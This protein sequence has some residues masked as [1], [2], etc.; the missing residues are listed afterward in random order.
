MQPDAGWPTQMTAAVS[1][2]DD[3]DIF[4]PWQIRR[5]RCTYMYLGFREELGFGK[6][7]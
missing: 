5:M 7:L 4:G 6:G 2:V 1:T 3:I